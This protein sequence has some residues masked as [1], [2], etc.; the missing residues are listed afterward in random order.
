MSSSKPTLCLSQTG[1][2]FVDNLGKIYGVDLFM[3]IVILS[4]SRYLW[5]ASFL[6]G[7][8]DFFRFNFWTFHA[9]EKYE[10]SDIHIK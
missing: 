9:I 8:P 5:C 7:S 2:R 1:L 4:V 6:A 10:G 3:E